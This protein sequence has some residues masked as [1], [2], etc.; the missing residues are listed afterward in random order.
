MGLVVN[1]D[2]TSWI[3]TR[4]NPNPGPFARVPEGEI[5]IVRIPSLGQRVIRWGKILAAV[6]L[7]SALMRSA[8]WLLGELLNKVR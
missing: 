6:F 1:A 2:G 4:S 5:S 8:F 3:D 7:L